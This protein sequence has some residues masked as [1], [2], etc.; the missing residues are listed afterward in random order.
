MVGY[1][2]GGAYTWWAIAT[3]GSAYT[4]WAIATHGGA[5]TWWAIATHGDACACFFTGTVSFYT[6]HNLRS[7][8]LYTLFHHRHSKSKTRCYH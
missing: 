5:Y 8:G 2:H 4:W 7:S 3:H 6:L 1:S